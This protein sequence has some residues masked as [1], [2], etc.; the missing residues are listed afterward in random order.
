MEPPRS[1]ACATSVSMEQC[2]PPTRCL[3]SVIFFVF[4]RKQNSCCFRYKLMVPIDVLFF[5]FYFTGQ[6]NF[7]V[8]CYIACHVMAGSTSNENGIY[9]RGIASAM[10][11]MYACERSRSMSITQTTYNLYENMYSGLQFKLVI[12][13]SRLAK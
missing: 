10:S 12:I 6:R 5:I 7:M 1:Y 8:K 9:C 3:I 2:T 13:K 11:Y 4:V